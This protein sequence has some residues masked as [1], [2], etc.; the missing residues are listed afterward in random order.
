MI[1]VE[2]EEEKYGYCYLLF[3]YKVGYQKHKQ[4]YQAYGMR[5]ENMNIKMILFISDFIL[6]LLYNL[7]HYSIII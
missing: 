6:S 1:S 7:Y 3:H 2:E 5:N 4:P